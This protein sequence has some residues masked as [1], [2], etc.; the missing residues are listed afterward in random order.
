MY[1]LEFLDVFPVTWLSS[2]I[3]PPSLHPGTQLSFVHP[4]SSY[5]IFL[6]GDCPHAT[7]TV[8]LSSKYSPSLNISASLTASSP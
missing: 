1:H 6:S 8:H 3:S 2:S 7:V 4:T 5:L